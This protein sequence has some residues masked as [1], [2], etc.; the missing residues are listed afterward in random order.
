MSNEKKN[1]CHNAEGKKLES[2]QLTR[3]SRHEIKKKI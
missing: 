3:H 2:V 1:Q